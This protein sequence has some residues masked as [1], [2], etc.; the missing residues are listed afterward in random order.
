VNWTVVYTR[1]APKDAQQLVDAGLEEK[2]VVLLDP[3]ARSLGTQSFRN[4]PTLR[5]AGR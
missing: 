3:F 4:S 2:A 5:E 1:Q